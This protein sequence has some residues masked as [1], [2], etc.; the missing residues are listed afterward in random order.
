[1]I[2]RGRVAVAALALWALALFLSASLLTPSAGAAGLSWSTRTAVGL[3]GP[4][5][6]TL[7]SEATFVPSLTSGVRDVGELPGSNA[8]AQIAN[9]SQNGERL[10]LV[11]SDPDSAWSL[12]ASTGTSVRLGSS[13]ITPLANQSPSG[14]YTAWVP[15]AS[16][17]AC[18]R[19]IYIA[20]NGTETAPRPVV[21][22]RQYSH[23]SVDA[24]AVS[25]TGVVTVGVAP[26]HGRDFFANSAILTGGPR[27]QQLAVRAA[28]HAD[29][30]EG[31]QISQNGRVFVGCG[32]VSHHGQSSPEMSLIDSRA[33]QQLR[34]A[35]LSSGSAPNCIASNAGTATMTAY[36]HAGT[37]ASVIVGLTIGTGEKR[38]FRFAA[39]CQN[40]G[41]D[42]GVVSPS[43]AQVVAGIN[44][45][46]IS[47]HQQRVTL[48]NTTTAQSRSFQHPFGYLREETGVL[49]PNTAR[50]WSS[51][52]FW[53]PF[54]PA[55]GEMDSF[56]GVVGI[57]NS[58]TL[59]SSHALKIFPPDGRN[60]KISPCFLPSGR[61]LF[62]GRSHGKY[63][64]LVTNATR[65]RVSVIDTTQIGAISSAS[66]EAVATTGE[67]FLTTPAGHVYAVSADALDGS[68][69]G[70]G[71]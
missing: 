52:G 30:P 19:S 70:L 21:L 15:R 64:V 43:G 9:V 41:G 28:Y 12:D 8:A 1:M 58:Q 68:P 61:I 29:W 55:L 39:D 65:T 13:A 34:T 49:G 17:D 71:G 46:S 33:P 38:P 50:L 45:H 51:F 35:Q 47:C 7:T 14:A 18:P 27:D 24:I 25:D 26:C 57:L 3:A 66:C 40:G 59:K 67:V 62:V 20:E 56:E 2:G 10:L 36:R 32:M 23:A 69:L 11:T 48:I 53:D 4:D 31:W 16:Y 5:G 60:G 54:A 6:G 22:P 42:L 44:S 63:S 37:P